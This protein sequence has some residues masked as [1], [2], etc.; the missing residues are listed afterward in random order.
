LLEKKAAG[1]EMKP[2]GDGQ[3][4]CLLSSLSL[5]T[6]LPLSLPPPHQSSMLSLSLSGSR[7]SQLRGDGALPLAGRR[8]V[9]AVAQAHVV[10]LHAVQGDARVVGGRQGGVLGAVAELLAVGEPLGVW[11]RE[12]GRER[13][14]ERSPVT[15]CW[16]SQIWHHFQSLCGFTSQSEHKLDCHTHTHTHTH[17]GRRG[18]GAKLS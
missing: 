7:R 14:A 16:K 15:Q 12:R 9:G 17:T 8:H 18:C 11:G 5:T 6:L 13:S 2:R 1:N 3:T 4:C 10:A